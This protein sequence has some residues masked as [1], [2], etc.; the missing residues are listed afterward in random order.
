MPSGE[1][2]SHINR[3][4]ADADNG[5]QC[6]KQGNWVKLNGLC[7]DHYERIHGELAPAVS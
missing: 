6:M 7:F 1:T 3:C 5:G 4:W 2:V